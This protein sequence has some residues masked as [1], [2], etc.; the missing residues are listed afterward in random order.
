[1]IDSILL[2]IKKMIGYEDDYKV[3]DNDL[4][5]H[6]NGLIARLN[7][8]GPTLS[9]DF[10]ITGESETWDDYFSKLSHPDSGDWFTTTNLQ[11]IKDFIYINTKIIFDPPTS[12]FVLE[13][14]K[15]QAKEMEWRLACFSDEKE[16]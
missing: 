9:E 8:I 6:I 15:E 16:V 1:M 5:I 12:S 3:F 10:Y 4:I 2:T 7:Q 11:M 14:L 13:A